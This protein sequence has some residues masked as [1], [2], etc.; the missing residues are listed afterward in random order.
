MYHSEISSTVLSIL[1]LN[2]PTTWRFK[3]FFLNFWFSRLPLHPSTWSISSCT[4]YNASGHSKKFTDILWYVLQVLQNFWTHCIS[5]CPH[6]ST[7]TL[8]NPFQHCS[9][10]IEVVQHMPWWSYGPQNGFI[11]LSYMLQRCVVEFV[12]PAPLTSTAFPFQQH[13]SFLPPPPPPL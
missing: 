13:H 12:V 7:R 3:L 11:Y 4:S 8:S 6:T 5:H 2:A 9:P 1:Y 10:V